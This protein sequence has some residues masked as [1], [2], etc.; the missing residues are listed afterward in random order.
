MALGDPYGTLQ[1]LKDRLS[2]VD[3]D[4]DA[5]LTSALAAASRGVN[6]FCNRQFNKTT[7]ATGRQFD[8]TTATLLLVDDFHTTTDLVV[9]GTAYDSSVHV[10][11]P[12]NGMVDGEPGWPYWRIR[13]AGGDYTTSATVTVTAQ[14]G[15]A[16][17]PA[18]V[19]E[20]ALIT[21]MEITKLSDAPF[22]VQGNAEMGLI[23]IRENHRISS[24]LAPYRRRAVA[25]A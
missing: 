20:A 23:R 12:L 4:D 8:A 21:A 16:E 1:D 15:W 11:E 2:I 5:E 3:T 24:M 25:V 19:T 18:S 9:D 6:R 17:V 14:W 13:N 22:G 10:L 7:T